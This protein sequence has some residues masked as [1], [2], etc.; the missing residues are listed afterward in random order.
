MTED[1]VQSIVEANTNTARQA[2]KAARQLQYWKREK[3]E[4]SEYNSV[5]AVTQCLMQGVGVYVMQA[6]VALA[7][8]LYGLSRASNVVL[9]V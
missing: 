9:R 1:A 7:S 4:N 2:E 6:R 8:S 3:R 5:C